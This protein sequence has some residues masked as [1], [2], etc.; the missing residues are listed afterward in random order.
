[1]FIYREELAP[2]GDKYAQYMIGYMHEH[3]K[4]VDKDPAVASPGIASPSGARARILRTR[5]DEQAGARW[6]TMSCSRP[7]NVARRVR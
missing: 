2:L 7:S 4:G 3:G 6:K 1:M 5:H